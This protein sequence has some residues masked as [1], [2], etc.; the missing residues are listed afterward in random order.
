MK[1]DEFPVFT[2]QGMADGVD[3]LRKLWAGETVSYNGPAGDYPA[4][5]LAHKCDNPPP[6]ILGAVGPKTLALGGAHF[7]GYADHPRIRERIANGP[8]AGNVSDA[9][10][11][12]KFSV[13]VTDM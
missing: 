3:I 13:A 11:M 12:A 4:M 2:N 5:Q 6:L 9:A 7:D 8:N 1:L 10:A